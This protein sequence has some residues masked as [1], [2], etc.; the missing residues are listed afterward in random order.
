VERKAIRLA[1][2][3]LKKDLLDVGFEEDDIETAS[4]QVQG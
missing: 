2:A 1:I 3:D 4:V